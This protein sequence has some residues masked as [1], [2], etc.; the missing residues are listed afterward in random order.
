MSARSI[1]VFSRCCVN[2]CITLSSRGFVIFR[3]NAYFLR[4]NSLAISCLSLSRTRDSFH[5]VIDRSI[6][7]L[8]RRGCRGGVPRA[9]TGQPGRVQVPS[10]THQ[11]AGTSRGSFVDAGCVAFTLKGSLRARS[12][13]LSQVPFGRRTKGG[14][15]GTFSLA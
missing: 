10:P 6:D 14:R 12:L 7:V 4:N 3:A 1:G 11:D 2:L 13:L 5:V 8:S 15:L 9:A